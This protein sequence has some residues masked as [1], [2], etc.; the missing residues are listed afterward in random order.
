MGALTGDPKKEK[1]RIEEQTHYSAAPPNTTAQQHQSSRQVPSS[2][3]APDLLS[4]DNTHVPPQQVFQ[5]QGNNTGTTQS[6][7]RP[8]HSQNRNVSQYPARQSQHQVYASATAPTA[9]APS[10]NVSQYPAHQSQHQV[11]NRAAP[12]AAASTAPQANRADNEQHGYRFGK[13]ILNTDFEM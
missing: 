3:Q 5:R 12:S 10:R 4:S 13:Y 7:V 8:R 2:N 1:Q 11:N 6:N 9:P